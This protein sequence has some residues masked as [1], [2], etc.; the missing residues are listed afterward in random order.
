VVRMWEVFP[1]PAARYNHRMS[2]PHGEDLGTGDILPEKRGP[3]VRTSYTNWQK[4]KVLDVYYNLESN[5]AVQFPFTETCKWAFGAIWEKRKGYLTKWLAKAERIRDLT[6][7]GG[8]VAALA[9][10]PIA[11]SR[12]ALYPDCE[13][14]LPGRPSTR[15]VLCPDA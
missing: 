2:C 10:D 15:K 5:P 8:R 1:H 9:R 12:K 6:S 13:G 11:G 4:A 14:P 3:G 7:A